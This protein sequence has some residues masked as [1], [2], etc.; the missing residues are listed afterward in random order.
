M[1]VQNFVIPN[2]SMT[3]NSEL[4]PTTPAAAG[5]LY[6][7]ANTSLN[8]AWCAKNVTK[9]CLVLAEFVCF[10]YVYFKYFQNMNEIC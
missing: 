8:G 5:R 6:L 2:K 10:L 7:K 3:T 9:V 4:N 1:G